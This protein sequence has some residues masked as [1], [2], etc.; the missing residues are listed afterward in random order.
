MVRLY[1]GGA[2]AWRQLEFCAFRGAARFF[3][4]AGAG[5]PGPAPA[6]PLVALPA[7]LFH[8]SVFAVFRRVLHPEHFGGRP[9]CVG[10]DRVEPGRDGRFCLGSHYIAPVPSGQAGDILGG[11]PAVCSLAG[12]SGQDLGPH[13][14][15]SVDQGSGPDR[16]DPPLAGDHLPS[17]AACRAVRD[18]FAEHHVR[19]RRNLQ[20]VYL[21]QVL[22]IMTDWQTKRTGID[23]TL[24]GIF[25]MVLLLPAILVFLPQSK[26][27][28]RLTEKRR[29]A[30][31]PTVPGDMD[32]LVQ[33]P[34]KFEHYFDDHFPFRTQ[35]IQGHNYLR[36]KILKE[37]DQ[38]FV[39]MGRDGWLFYTG[40]KL[41]EDFCGQVPYT[42]EKMEGFRLMVEAKRDWLAARGI[43]YIF[44]I[45]PNKQTIYPEH[46]A[47]NFL[48]A[49]GRT[50]MDQL[51]AFMQAHSDVTIVD[52]RQPLIEAKSQ[53]PLY[54]LTDTHWNDLG[55]LIGYGEIMK[56]VEQALGRDVGSVRTLEDYRLQGRSARAAIWPQSWA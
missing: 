21:L 20:P 31:R 22:T 49:R 38:H 33:Y 23:F 5:W 44:V 42:D 47:E 6:A 25:M 46:M 36:I 12:R 4:G 43:P 10:H 29:L 14:A 18:L 45:P 30:E 39:V 9:L 52:L 13:P 32:A 15:A 55:V 35:L 40:E 53:D 3:H 50:R 37:S 26:P 48:R 11:L 27:G 51:M 8:H 1:T 54:Y 28:P 19:G 16:Y 7:R 17:D 24:V 56:A 34:R 2:L 41:L